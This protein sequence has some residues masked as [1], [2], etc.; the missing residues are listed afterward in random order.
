MQP[1]PLTLD[2]QDIALR[3]ALT[4]VAGALIGINR[5]DRGRPAGL[6]TTM[7]V[8]LAAAVAM[9]QANILLPTTGRADDS[10]VDLDLMRLP[11]GI[12]SGVGFL[13]AGAIL[14]RS[15]MVVGITTAATLWIVT[16]IGLCFGGGQLT[17]G[18]TATVIAL[19]VLWG[20]EHLETYIPRDRRATLSIVL[21]AKVMTPHD[22]IQELVDAGLKVSAQSVKY[23]D[24][25]DCAEVRYELRWRGLRQEA[26]PPLSLR[27]MAKRPGIKT[28]QWRP[29]NVQD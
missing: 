26:E 6:R 23:L 15:N 4:V 10:F 13:G 8:C 14:R 24:N 11:L 9:I 25:A 20:L 28:L 5:D 16:V 12:L 1:M 18:I 27:D 19:V 29:N 3:L 7:L 21:D 17:L 2:W 22:V